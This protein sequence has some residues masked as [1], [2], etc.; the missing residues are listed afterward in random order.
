MKTSIV[1][2]ARTVLR[3]VC[4]LIVL[5]VATFGGAAFAQQV[6]ISNVPLYGG[7]QPHPN[8]AVTAS[9]EFPTVGA[10][11]LNTDHY[12]SSTSYLG[13]FDPTKCYSFDSTYGGFFRPSG[14]ANAV[15]EC[16]NAFSGSFM[17]WATMSA[18]DEFRYA[19][20]GGNRVEENGPSNGTI[21]QRATLP[22]G[23]VPGV[24]S[25]YNLSSNFPTQGMDFNGIYNTAQNVYYNTSGMDKVLPDSLTQSSPF[26]AYASCGAY[27]YVGYPGPD[28]SSCNIA[29]NGSPNNILPGG[30]LPIRVLVCDDTEGPIRTDLCKQYGGTGGKY[31]PVGQAQVNAARMR[32]AAFGYLM[33]HNTNDGYSV[34]PGCD[35]GSSWSRC[36]YGGVLRAP[37]KYVGPTSYDANQ[38]SGVNPH[39]EINADGTQNRDPEGTALSATGYSGFINYIN[40]FGATG[41]YK[42]YDTMGEMYYEAI[43]YYQNLGPTPLAASGALTDAVKDNFPITTSWVDPIGSICSANYIIN[44]SDANVWD[45][46]YLPGYNGSPS[47]GYARPSS[48]PVEGG[49][50]AHLWAS[51]IGTLEST[52]PSLVANDVRPNLYNMADINTT[53]GTASYAV[54]GAAFWANVNDIRTDLVGKQTIKT[55][56]FDVAEPSLDIHD[57]QLYLMGK[58]GGFNNTIDR[59]SDTYANPFYA[60]DPS[61]PTSPAIRSNSE[62]ED[63]LNS[64]YPANYLLASDP[65]KLINGLRNAFARI[66]AQTGTLSGAALTSANLTYG[67]AGAYIATFD[68]GRW[69][70]SV[71]FDSLSVDVLT[72][73]LVVSATPIWD[74]GALLSSRCGTVS[75]G[76]TVCTD[77]DSSVNKRNIFTTVINAG[78]RQAVP[79]T[80]NDIATR[81]P[82]YLAI[83]NTNPASNVVDNLG[84]QR[85]NFLRGYRFDES[86]A[87]GFR[88][89]DSAMG[90]VVNSGPVYVGPPTSSI[91]DADYQSFYAANAARTPAVYVGANDGMLHALRASDGFELFAYIPGYESADLNDLTNP[92]YQHEVFVDTVPK[93]Q[94]AKVGNAWKT[95]LLGANGNGSQGIF[96]LDVS[97]PSVFDPTK[98]LFEFSDV[99]DADLGN[100]IAAPEIAKLWVSGPATAPVYRYFAVVTGYNKTR[101]TENFRADTHISTDTLNKGVLFL[102]GLDHTLGTAWVL[103]TDYYKY[104]FPAANNTLVNG[105]APVTLL[106]SKTGDRSTA[107]M[108]FG[109]L[110]GDLWKFNTYTGDPSTFAPALGSIASPSPIFVAQDASNNRQPITAR[111]ELSNGPYGSTLIY[112]GTGEYLGAF[113]PQPTRQR[114][115]RI[116]AARPESIRP[117]H[118]FDRPGAAGRNDLGFCRHGH[119]GR[120]LVQRR[121]F[122]EGLVPGLPEQSRAGGTQHHQTRGADGAADV[123]HAHAVQ[124]PVPARQWLCLPGQ[125]VDRQGGQRRRDDD[126]LL[127][128]GRHSGATARGGPDPDERPD[129]GDRRSDQPIDPDDAGLGDGWQD[130]QLWPAGTDQGTTDA[131]DQL[132]RN[133]QLER[134]DGPLIVKTCQ[135]PIG[136]STAPTV[137]AGQRGFSLIELMIVVAIIAILAAIAVPSYQDSVWKGKRAE[138]K[139]AILKAL[140]AEERLYSNTNSYKAYS[141]SSDVPSSAF[142]LYSA[143]N[144]SNSRYTIQV[145]AA[146]VAPLCTDN[147]VT[148]CAIVIATVVGSPDPKCGATLSMDTVGNKSSATGDDFCWK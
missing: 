11:Y 56:S 118:A 86:S 49:L 87:L 23:S 31:K 42:R 100:V 76:S 117:D 75:S 133:H 95:V 21:I 22:D 111:V 66:N 70:G 136:T 105:L 97:D 101:T 93:V 140:Q 138:A 131:A 61:N 6:D 38:I 19:M 63:T 16:S 127:V 15:H 74:A 102:I 71:L 129:A 12:S 32:F 116:L 53:A 146:G 115:V 8:V 48:R 147:D 69:S 41:V 84:Q 148:K 59:T 104:T 35:D 108:Y 14:D 78:V 2:T 30:A 90:D 51:Y 145:Q 39:S 46:T 37:M 96:A 77:S 20:T 60:I 40:K 89:R 144:P 24:P 92:A 91:P 34:P 52:T 94:E 103:G 28:G 79:F 5:C 121:Q 36:R 54:A 67:S 80:Y 43:R 55:I 124:R 18:I 123:H 65:Q 25:F 33:D 73:N 3:T 99:D 26:V 29:N 125:R 13:Y 47:P 142:P 82:S 72:G 62:W 9:V 88:P 50:D 132:A 122:E 1:R 44:L 4:P 98:V 126:R 137:I 27:F 143:D 134:P 135:S 83:L 17:N 141:S 109:D 139:A 113:G 114:A 64:A 68:P 57:R 45:D 58:Y 10:A 128:D 120:L 119:R 7:R 130:R 112:F 81:D 85:V 106:A 110:Q 107:S